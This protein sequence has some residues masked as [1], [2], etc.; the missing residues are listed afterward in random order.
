M[1]LSFIVIVAGTENREQN[2]ISTVDWGKNP[3]IFSIE[4]SSVSQKYLLQRRCKQSREDAVKSEQL[5]QH[6]IRRYLSLEFKIHIKLE[7]YQNQLSV[8]AMRATDT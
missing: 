1:P 5:R 7:Q 2:E 3:S 6:F 4:S 8:K